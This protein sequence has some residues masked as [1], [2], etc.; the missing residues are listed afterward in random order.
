MTDVTSRTLH[1]D[2]RRFLCES[3]S[4][5]RFPSAKRASPIGPR[6]YLLSC[7]GLTRGSECVRVRNSGTLLD[8][9]YESVVFDMYVVEAGLR[10]QEEGH[11]A[12][13]MDTVSDS[14]LAAL[15]SRPD[16]PVLGPGLA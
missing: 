3:S 6:R 2:W 8:S 14:G 10:A 4:S 13:I 15:R 12:V 9:Y 1:S 16:I 11:D 5:S 7:S